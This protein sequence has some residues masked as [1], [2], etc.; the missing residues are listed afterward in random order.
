MGGIELEV[1]MLTMGYWPTQSVPPCT[2]PAPIQACCTGFEAFYLE[3]H[4]GKCVSRALLCLSLPLWLFIGIQSVHVVAESML[5]PFPDNPNTTQ[6]GRWC[7][8]RGW[9][10]RTSR[11]TSGGGGTT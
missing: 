9:G 3:K 5:K 10:A 7:G 4:Q 1:N 11:P 8:R 2:L 6:G